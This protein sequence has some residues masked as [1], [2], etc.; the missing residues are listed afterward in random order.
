MSTQSQAGIQAVEV[1]SPELPAIRRVVD[2]YAEALR[3]GSVDAMN[4]AFHPQAI[5]SGYFND[6]LMLMDM[7]GFAGLIG[8]VEP[9][10]R[11]GE[12]YRC[13]IRDTQVTGNIAT[14]EIIEYSLLGHDFKTCFQL[15]KIDDRWQITG[16][17]FTT[18]GPAE[19]QD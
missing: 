4:R 10:S 9:P 14:V 11:T 2:D 7:E 12:P 13:E 19:P 17:L 1:A 16:K 18:L 8:S 15:T 3:D 5:M 6:D